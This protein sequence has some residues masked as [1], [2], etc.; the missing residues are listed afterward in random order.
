MTRAG[1]PLLAAPRTLRCSVVWGGADEGFGGVDAAIKLHK[2]NVNKYKHKKI[3][4]PH[5]MIFSCVAVVCAF[6]HIQV[7]IH[8]TPRPETT[9]CEYKEGDN[10]TISSPTLG[11]ARGS[12][13]VLLTKNHR[14]STS[15]FRARAPAGSGISPT[16]PSVARAERN[17]PY[18]R[19]WFW[20]SYPC[21]PSADPQSKLNNVYI[22]AK[23]TT[24]I[25]VTA[26]AHAT[27]DEESLC[28][29]KLVELFFIN[30]SRQSFISLGRVGLQ[31]FNIFMVE[32]QRYGRLWRACPIKKEI[33]YHTQITTTKRIRYK[34]RRFKYLISSLLHL[35]ISAKEACIIQ[36][37]YL[38]KPINAK[39]NK[40]T[41]ANPAARGVRASRLRPR[42]PPHILRQPCVT[43]RRAVNLPIYLSL[44][45][46]A[47]IVPL[48]GKGFERK[49]IENISQTPLSDYRR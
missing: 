40:Q 17:A 45:I 46:L 35:G 47:V 28:D 11:S 12:V 2:I 27:D 10:H 34:E 33:Y 16:G 36:Y 8:I 22:Y 1:A 26:S 5:T 24:N 49:V 9:I 41:R 18:A 31:C 3:T 19:V 43:P 42:T 7:Q 44:F 6:T 37:A 32:L 20:S 23:R 25:Y 38:L 30:D 48:Q 14:F 13:R 39:Y 21:S 4:F 29:L 15:T